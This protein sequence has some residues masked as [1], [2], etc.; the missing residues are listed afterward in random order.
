MGCRDRTPADNLNILHR[1][2]AAI[3]AAAHPYTTIETDR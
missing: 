1:L 2:L 3:L